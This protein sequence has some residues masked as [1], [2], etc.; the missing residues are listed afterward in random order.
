M[1]LFFFFFFATD[2]HI[3]THHNPQFMLG[4][5][6]GVVRSLGLNKCVMM[7]ELPRDKAAEV[8]IMQGVRPS[9]MTRS[10]AHQ[11]RLN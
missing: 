8:Q 4:L 9:H 11:D 1:V 10:T 5:T 2:E 3:L 6:L 7:C